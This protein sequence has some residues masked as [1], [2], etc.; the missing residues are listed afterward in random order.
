MALLRLVKPYNPVKHDELPEMVEKAWTAFE[1][2]EAIELWVAEFDYELQRHQAKA[3]A[4]GYGIR[5]TLCDGGEIFLH[6]TTD[7]MILLDV[8]PDAA[9]IEPVITASTRTRKPVGQIWILPADTLTQ[10]L[11]GINTLVASSKLV[12]EHRFRSTV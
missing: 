9:W 4:V 12:L 5:F 3:N 11:F 6:T 2:I 7:G 10:F 1:S 8:T